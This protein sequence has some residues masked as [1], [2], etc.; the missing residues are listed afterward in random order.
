[1][2]GGHPDV[3]AVEQPLGSEAVLDPLDLAVDMPQDGDGLGRSDPVLVGCGVE[4]AEPEHRHCRPHAGETNVQQGVDG[5]AIE[6]A[7]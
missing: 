2:V 1:M 4:I 5:V 7:R 6:R 3:V